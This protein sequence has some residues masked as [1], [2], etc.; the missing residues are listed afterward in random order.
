MPIAGAIDV[1]YGRASLPAQ[2]YR[3]TGNK[4]SKENV[5]PT[6]KEMMNRKGKLS[7]RVNG[8]AARAGKL[9]TMDVEPS[10]ESSLPVEGFAITAKEFIRKRVLGGMSGGAMRI[11]TPSKVQ[12]KQHGSRVEQ[13]LVISSLEALTGNGKDV[14]LDSGAALA[15]MRSSA[16]SMDAFDETHRGGS[17]PVALLNSPLVQSPG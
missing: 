16:A 10:E 5:G 14:P 4:E 1:E 13:S 2:S 17:L 12:K 7:R 9:E 15:L 11:R 3:G 8:G 6:A